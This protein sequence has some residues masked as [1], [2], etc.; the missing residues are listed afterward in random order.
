MRNIIFHRYTFIFSVL[1]AVFAVNYSVKAQRDYKEGYI[2]TPEGDTVFGYIDLQSNVYNS[3]ECVFTTIRDEQPKIF[4]PFEIA[5]YRIT[6]GKYYV[7]KEILLNET[8]RKV[9]LEFLV[10]GIIDLYYYKTFNKEY[11][12]IEK[13]GRLHELSNEEREVYVNEIRY[14]KNSNQYKGMLTYLFKDSPEVSSD[15][16]NTKFNYKGLINI[17]REYHENVCQDYDCIDFTHSTRMVIMM[18]TSVGIMN[19][20]YGYLTSDIYVQQLHP[21]V[22]V[23]IR[24]KPAKV[25]YLWNYITGI[26]FSRNNYLGDYPNE[27]FQGGEKI[28]RI[29]MDYSVV[30]IPL[31]AEYSFP[32]KS[33]RPFISFEYLNC[34]LLNVE[35]DVRRV[36]S[37]ATDRF[38]ESVSGSLN[39]DV[40]KYEFGLS[41]GTGLRYCR[42]NGSYF[43]LKINY[44]YQDPIANFKH[45]MDYRHSHALRLTAGFGFNIK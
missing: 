18:E 28:F 6:G 11:Y 44:I 4:H 10:D 25:H 38:S 3:L 12:F 23:D 35:Y 16:N 14:L 19:S 15:I 40:R 9:F 8:E 45:I 1:I 13:D 39:S 36:Y 5:A 29:D 33:L 17:T 2:I 21:V 7:S 27:V 34:F 24:I 32:G 26:R 43:H 42:K 37:Y 20:W 22:G 31:I 30:E 41:A